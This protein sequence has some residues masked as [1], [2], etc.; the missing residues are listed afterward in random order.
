MRLGLGVLL[1]Q[2]N[3]FSGDVVNLDRGYLRAILS[4][5]AMSS[6]LHLRWRG[7]WFSPKIYELETEEN[8]KGV[9]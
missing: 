3:Q 5:L 7:M 2:T 8:R 1:E 9:R 6:L 4:S